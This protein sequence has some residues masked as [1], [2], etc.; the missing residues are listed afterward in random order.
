MATIIKNEDL[1]RH[2]PASLQAFNLADYEVEARRILAS[3]RKQVGLLLA[4]AATK[5]ARLAEEARTRG[6]QEGFEKGLDE[7]RRV[8]RDE[9]Y[10]Q[11]AEEFAGQQASLVQ[12]CRQTVAGIDEQ[13]R[14][15][16]L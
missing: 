15:L 1:A 6:H 4:D 5:A 11:A 9:A 10:K 16:L 14:R 13:K 8:G 7:G 3:A 12:V 2:G